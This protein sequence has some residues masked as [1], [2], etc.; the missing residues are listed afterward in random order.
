[1]NAYSKI[2]VAVDLSPEAKQ[3][4]A[5]AADIAE[6]HGAQLALVHVVE[7]LITDGAYELM[8]ALPVEVETTLVERAVQF[9]ERVADE[10]G[11][12]DTP[13]EVRIGSVKR[14]ILAYAGELGCDLIVIGTHGRH[15]LATL[16][17]ATANAILHGT[18]CDV[19][20]VRVGER[21]A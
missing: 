11:M 17:G 9:L 13:R 1:M 19:L 4:I 18:Q 12:A 8:P 16:L 5:R 10:A 21:E 15:G 20:C 2:L 14:E 3:I 7:P 6:R